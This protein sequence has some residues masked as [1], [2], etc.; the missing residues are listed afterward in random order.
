VRGRDGFDVVVEQRLLVEHDTVVLQFP[1][2]WY[3]VPGLLKEWIDQVLTY[4]F[5]YGSHGTAL[6]GKPLQVVTTTGGPDV[7][8]QPDGHNRFTM[9]ELMRPPRGH[10]AP[11]RHDSRQSVRRAWRA[12]PRRRR[13]GV[14][15]CPLPSPARHRATARHHLKAGEDPFS[16]GRQHFVVGKP[17]PKLQASRQETK[18]FIR[19]A[20]IVTAR[21]H[22]TSARQAPRQ[23]L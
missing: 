5:A 7:S 2:Y 20:P 17:G 4:G 6:E 10:R 9:G 15:R 18:Q 23:G 16:R 12:D 13:A 21:R 22:T 1:W 3:S 8:Y 14:V 11:V 19:R